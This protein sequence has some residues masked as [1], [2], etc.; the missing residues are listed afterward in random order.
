[1]GQSGTVIL[2]AQV[3][4]LWWL[5]T[6]R[7]EDPILTSSTVYIFKTF[8]HLHKLNLRK[9]KLWQTDRIG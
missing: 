5:L 7:R 4:G 9:E 2:G 6:D 3:K 8:V 1:M